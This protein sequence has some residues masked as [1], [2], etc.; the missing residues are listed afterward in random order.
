MIPLE[1]FIPAWIL[2]S[3]VS[4]FL[5][6]YYNIKYFNDW[7]YY[8]AGL[9]LLY[10]L[11]CSWC[12]LMLLFCFRVQSFLSDRGHRRFINWISTSRQKNKWVMKE[13]TFSVNQK[14]F[15]IYHSAPN[16]NPPMY[17]TVLFKSSERKEHLFSKLN[18]DGKCDWYQVEMTDGTLVLMPSTCLEDAEESISRTQYMLETHK[19][20]V[21][22]KGFSPESYASLNKNVKDGLK[23]IQ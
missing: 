11:L 2:G 22:E 20:R 17:G 6:R 18:P 23:F 8:E 21:G 12:G 15:A 4:F 16:F 10:C 1:Y 7:T 9:Y 3:I 19:H 5:F 13:K 14:V